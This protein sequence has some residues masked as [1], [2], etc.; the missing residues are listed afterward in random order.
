MAFDIQK[1]KEAGASDEAIAAHLSKK[2]NFNI[3]GATESGASATDIVTHLMK[4]ETPVDVPQPV[5]AT[6]KQSKASQELGGTDVMTGDITSGYL[7]GLKDP[8]TAGAQLLPRGL[9]AITSLGYQ[10]PNPVSNF[11]G[12]EAQRVDKLARTDEANYQQQRDDNT[13]FDFQRLAGNIINPAIVVPGAVT[14]R[15]GPIVQS[16]AT[17]AYGGAQ[18]PVLNE[19][20]FAG[21]KAQQ[22]AIGAVA[23]PIFQGA[24]TGL[25]KGV[26]AIKKLTPKNRLESVRSALIEAAGDDLPAVTRELQD[27]AEFV[28]GSRPT[29]AEALSNVPSAVQLTAIQKRI[30]SDPVVGRKFTVLQENNRL[31]REA[32]LE[33]IKKTD[34]ERLA[35]ETAR[36]GMF[37]NVGAKALDDANV[38]R[39]VL[40]EL[41]ET[42]NTKFSNLTKSAGMDKMRPN[43]WG[44]FAGGGT[45]KVDQAAKAVYEKQMREFQL[46]SLEQNGFFPLLASDIVAP[47]NKALMT[48]IGDDSRAI[49]NGAKLDILSRADKDGIVSSQDLYTNVRKVLNQKVAVYLNKGEAPFQG[50]LPKEQA[51]AATSIKKMIDASLNK[52][53]GGG[54]GRYLKGYT[55]YSKQLNRMAV[56]EALSRK[57]NSPMDKEK[58]TSFANAVEEAAGLIKKSTGLPRY[59]NVGQILTTSENNQVK[60]V[61][62]DLTRKAK[63]EDLAKGMRV[64]DLSVDPSLPDVLS[65]PVA[66]TNVFLK[67]LATGNEAK[68]MKIAAPLFQNPKAMA[69]FINNVPKPNLVMKM[70]SQVSPNTQRAMLQAIAIK[71]TMMGTF[72]QD[73]AN[74][75]RNV[76]P[77]DPL[78]DFIQNLPAETQ[79]Q[80]RAT[81]IDSAV[82][83]VLPLLQKMKQSDPSLNI[84]YMYNAYLESTPEEQQAFLSKFN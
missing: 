66:F 82:T 76:S 8:I 19:G 1:A 31:A 51:D 65:R 57:L 16:I 11:F 27:A 58:A 70:L 53:T 44:A 12:A 32:V 79:G 36:N 30:A 52:T 13:S 43:G 45:G 80:S 15:G 47:I 4:K 28:T 38:A 42:V 46:D 62:A 7:M 14:A 37:E 41:Q 64:D 18:Q 34:A 69:A 67:L 68:I 3:Q 73:E 59:T 2:Y 5:E 40:N 60:A 20:S 54:W 6:G 29:V 75:E 63:A 77:S 33:G 83:K 21:D 71:P 56:G 50:G 74:M 61:L 17:G 81:V 49:L 55:D 78:G 39:R 10:L 72:Q 22:M 24:V 84:D 48:T 23:G 9:E 26:N 35:V 25:S